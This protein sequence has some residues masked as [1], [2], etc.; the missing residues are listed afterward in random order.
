MGS[1]VAAPF[2]RPVGTFVGREDELRRVHELGE[3]EVVFLIYGVGG[4]GKTE[5]AYKAI[6]E[7]RAREPWAKHEPVLLRAG[8]GTTVEHL[9]ARLVHGLGNGRG[10]PRAGGG[11][12]AEL[13]AAARALEARPT[14]VLL[15]DLHELDPAQAGRMLAFLCRHVRKSRVF[16]TSRVE[17]PLGADAHA[18]VSLRL[19]PLDA[20]ATA[21]LGARLSRRVGSACPDPRMLFRRS[22]GSPF[23]VQRE[24][25]GQG[26]DRDDDASLPTNGASCSSP[27]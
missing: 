20:F 23:F 27:P 19:A 24:L 18:A 22:G 17:L 8:A 11:L 10:Q 6:E 15:D 4:I 25:S 12:E 13:G 2:P 7:L 26:F 1:F 14:L 3:R 21:E 5:L 9:V 16:A